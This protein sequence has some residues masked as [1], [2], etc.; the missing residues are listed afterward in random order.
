M[1]TYASGTYGSPGGLYGRLS[2]RRL[3]RPA[4]VVLSASQVQLRLAAADA[5]AVHV[6]SS[7]R[8]LIHLAQV[9]VV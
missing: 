4:E 7:E 3:P 5:P 8:L 6:T 2:G 1:P 9:E